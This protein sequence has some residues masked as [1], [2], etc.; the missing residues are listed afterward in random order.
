MQILEETT[1]Q[2]QAI[3][4]GQNVATTLQIFRDTAIF[5]PRAD[6]RGVRSKASYCPAQLED[7]GVLQLLPN[8]HFVM[9]TLSTMLRALQSS[10]KMKL[11]YLDQLLLCSW[12]RGGVP[13]NFNGDLKSIRR[14]I[15][16]CV[17]EMRSTFESSTPPP[18]F[19]VARQ[20]SEY[21]P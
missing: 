15:K 2:S 3:F 14:E 17:R 9:Q 8:T 16:K 1:H 19:H 4:N 10:I 12:V 20:T 13:Q 6:H 21:P 5:H 11:H 7:V 18:R